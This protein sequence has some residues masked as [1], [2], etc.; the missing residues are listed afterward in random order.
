MVGGLGSI[1]GSLLGAVLLTAAPEVLRNFPGAEE[2]VFSL[3][4]IAVL[5]FMPNGLSG[6]LVRFFPSLRERLYRSRP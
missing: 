5:L 2:I 3:L 6:L 4:L 1:A